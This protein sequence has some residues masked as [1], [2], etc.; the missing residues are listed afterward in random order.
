MK[1]LTQILIVVKTVCIAKRHQR[2]CSELSVIMIWSQDSPL[3]LNIEYLPANTA[4]L[5]RMSELCLR[6]SFNYSILPQLSL[7]PNWIGQYALLDLWKYDSRNMQIILQ[8]NWT[9]MICQQKLQICHESASLCLISRYS[10]S[11]SPRLTWLLSGI[12][13]YTAIDLS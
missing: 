9:S 3:M 2:I 11:I 8:C 6:F 5:P 4:L 7:F 12:G 13:E 1:I 10:Y